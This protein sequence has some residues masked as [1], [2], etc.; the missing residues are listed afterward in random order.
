M[1]NVKILMHSQN[2]QIKNLLINKLLNNNYKLSKKRLRNKK[3]YYS[4]NSNK[5]NKLSNQLIKEV[6]IQMKKKNYYLKENQQ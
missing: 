5:L 6:F 4:N 3:K 1:N 2:K